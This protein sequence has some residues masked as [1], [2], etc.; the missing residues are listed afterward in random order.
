MHSVQVAGAGCGALGALFLRQQGAHVSHAVVLML[1]LYQ[2][3][4]LRSIGSTKAPQACDGGVRRVDLCRNMAQ[5][6]FR[7]HR[8]SRVVSGLMKLLTHQLLRMDTI[9]HCLARCSSGLTLV[10]WTEVGQ[11]GNCGHACN[12]ELP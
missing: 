2:C 11:T 12:F 6:M 7:H 3:F 5:T 1:K 9:W 4:A 8:D 10:V